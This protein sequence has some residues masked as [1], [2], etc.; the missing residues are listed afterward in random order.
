MG[1]SRKGKWGEFAR[2]ARLAP[3]RVHLHQE[4]AVLVMTNIYRRVWAHLSR[5]SPML[6][7]F[8]SLYPR[9]P[10]SPSCPCEAAT[11]T[12]LLLLLLPPPLPRL[13]KD[14]EDYS[15]KQEYNYSLFVLDRLRMC[16]VPDKTN[17]HDV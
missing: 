16:T 4:D 3:W 13:F 15:R 9:P 6:Q 10:Q 12:L 7:L 5:V 8:F 1:T 2:S 11:A 17:R 14:D